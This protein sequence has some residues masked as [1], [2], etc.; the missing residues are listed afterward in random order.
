M[1]TIINLSVNKTP[2]HNIWKTETNKSALQLFL[3]E[4]MRPRTDLN[5]TGIYNLL[6]KV[7]GAFAEKIIK[8]FTS[9]H[10]S[11]LAKLVCLVNPLA[12]SE[13]PYT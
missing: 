4:C 11:I 9:K 3:V 7:L 2:N 10:P 1:K 6:C 13:A 12:G 8:G 5:I